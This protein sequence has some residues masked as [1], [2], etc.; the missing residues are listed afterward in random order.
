[1]A[2]PM[3]WN[4]GTSTSPRLP[5]RTNLASAMSTLDKSGAGPALRLLVDSGPPLAVNSSTRV[6]N[7][8]AD[9]IDGKDFSGFVQGNATVRYR[10]VEIPAGTSAPIINFSDPALRVSYGCPSSPQTTNGVM[11]INYSGSE[12]VNVFFARHSSSST[13]HH[14]L[15]PGG[16]DSFS[17]GVQSTEHVTFQAQG[18]NLATIEVFTVERTSDCHAQ[19]QALVTR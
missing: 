19:A 16:L 10:K 8:N 7:L 5:S 3:S 2:H 12:P 11:F 14:L 18:T 1:M 17:L 6:A 9:Q 13:H 4:S 15:E